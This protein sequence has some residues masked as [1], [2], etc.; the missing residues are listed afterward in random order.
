MSGFVPPPA[1]DAGLDVHSANPPRERAVWVPVA[2][3]VE[4]CAAEFG[5][6][7]N[8]PAGSCKLLGK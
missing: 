5:E 7:Q 2:L 3:A 4:D 6:G 8:L 1:G